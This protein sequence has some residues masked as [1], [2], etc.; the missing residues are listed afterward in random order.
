[1][2][3]LVMYP[4]REAFL[5]MIQDP[6]YRRGTSDRTA[7]LDNTVFLPTKMA[8][9]GAAP[10]SPARREQLVI[11]PDFRHNPHCFE[12]LSHPSDG[13]SAQSRTPRMP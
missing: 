2:Q 6:A 4:F 13:G 9:V 3:L 1:M 11:S 5:G 7:R 10:G 8:L 12:G